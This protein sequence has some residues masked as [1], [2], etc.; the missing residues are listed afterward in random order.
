MKKL[1]ILSVLA[2]ASVSFA[3]QSVEARPSDKAALSTLQ[4][5]RTLVIIEGPSR[6]E[7]CPQIRATLVSKDAGLFMQSDAV[8][9]GTA[10]RMTTTLRE[11]AVLII[12]CMDRGEVIGTA[13]RKLT[14]G[15]RR[16]QIGGYNLADYDASVGIVP[17]MRSQ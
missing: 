9:V 2:L 6:T 11:D 1:L 14:P 8:K 12:Q 7:F 17:G 3:Q 16:Y 4:A 15:V 13:W 5:P 10:W